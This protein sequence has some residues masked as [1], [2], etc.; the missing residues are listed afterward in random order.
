MYLVEKDNNDD[1]EKC[2]KVKYSAMKL[3]MNDEK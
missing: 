2:E 3:E 1:D